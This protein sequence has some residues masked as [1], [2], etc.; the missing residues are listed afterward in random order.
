[1]LVLVWKQ[2][3]VDVHHAVS[4]TPRRWKFMKAFME[5]FI[6]SMEASTAS[7]EAWIVSIETFHGDGKSFRGV[8]HGSCE[9][10]QRKRGSFR[11]S[12]GIFHALLALLRQKASFE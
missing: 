1:M 12:D 4:E 6:S 9:S 10:F 7:M 5:A 2:A 3:T 11:G 8:F